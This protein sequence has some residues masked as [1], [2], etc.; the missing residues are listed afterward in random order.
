MVDRQQDL[1]KGSEGATPAEAVRPS[2]N[3]EVLDLPTFVGRD[4]ENREGLIAKFQRVLD[5]VNQQGSTIV[6]I[7]PIE[8]YQPFNNSTYISR[9]VLIIDTPKPPTSPTTENA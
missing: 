1:G 3:Y 6:G 7:I 4:I 5:R 8:R 9:H 2:H